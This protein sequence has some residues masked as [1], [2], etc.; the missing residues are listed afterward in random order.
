M[1]I[2][3]SKSSWRPLVQAAASPFASSACSS[4]AND[5]WPASIRLPSGLFQV[6][7]RSSSS[8]WIRNDDG[9]L[10]DRPICG[11]HIRGVFAPWTL[12]LEVISYRQPVSISE[13]LLTIP[14][15]RPSIYSRS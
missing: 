14:D 2:T 11:L 1:L 10:R 5:S 8:C 6:A 4:E 7:Y 12:P 3:F 13:E 9:Q 15:V